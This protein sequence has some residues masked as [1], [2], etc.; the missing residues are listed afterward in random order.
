MTGGRKIHKEISSQL[1]AEGIELG[2]DRLFAILG[3]NGMHVKPK[4]KGQRTTYSNHP[5]AVA[6]N[7]VKNLEITGPNQVVVADITY[8]RLLRGFCYLFLVTD[9]YSRKIVG[10][11]LSSSLRHEGA[12]SA[13]RMAVASISEDN[14][15]IH[16][17]D[18]GC[19]YCCHEFLGFLD[20]HKIIPSMTDEN[21]CYQNAVAE[22]VNGILKGELFLDST[23]KN[24]G[25]ARRAVVDAV[26][27]Y[28]NERLH[29][30]LNM[31]TPADV[32]QEA[33]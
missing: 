7:R 18:R 31:R 24:I 23:F 9:L 12:I 28:N 20:E 8:L 21:H 15:L 29:C 17:S 4:R 11:E 33:A 16:H 26:E 13:L 27:I 32:Y 3:E 5:Y 30:S 25:D 14:K 19:Q 6:P 22:R 1:Q 10:W 2:R